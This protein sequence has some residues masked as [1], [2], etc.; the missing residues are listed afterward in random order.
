MCV[1]AVKNNNLCRVLRNTAMIMVLDIFLQ[2]LNIPDY[3]IFTPMRWMNCF[4]LHES[5]LHPH[6]YNVVH[7]V[8][9]NKRKVRAAMLTTVK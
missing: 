4:C 6:R 5:T 1:R 8:T 7:T 9:S 3:E 2:Y